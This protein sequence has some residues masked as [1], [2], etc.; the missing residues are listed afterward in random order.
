MTTNERLPQEII[1][2]N[3]NTEAFNPE[4]IESAIYRCLNEGCELDASTSGTIAHEVSTRVLNILRQC[5]HTPTVED[6]QNV[7]I[8]QLWASEYFDAATRYVIYREARRK[9]RENSQPVDPYIRE[10]VEQDNKYFPT[11]YQRYQFLSKYSRYRDELGRRE[12]W[13]EAIDRTMLFLKKAVEEQ[14]GYR[15][16]TEDYN[17]LRLSMLNMEAFPAMRVFQMAGPALERCH[18][19]AYNCSFRAVDSLRAFSEILYVLMQ[20]SGVGFSVE[21]EYTDKLPRIKKA[22]KDQTIHYFIVEDSTE[23]WCDALLFGLERWFAGEDVIFNYD[24]I[25]KQGARLKIKG[26]RASGPEPL[27]GLL[28]FTR[29]KIS[30][31]WESG[32]RLETIECHDIVCKL[33]EIVMVGGVRRAAEISLS[34]LDDLA[35]RSAKHGQ[36]WMAE[37]QRAMANNSSVYEEKPTAEEFLEEWLSLIKSRTGERGIWNRAGYNKVKP[38]RRK[39]AKWG[40]NPCGEIALRN[41]QFCNLSI[42]IARAWDTEETLIE[43]VRQ[44]TIFG[45]LQST[46]TRFNY[47]GEEW[48]RNCEEERL[49][50]VDITGQLD[51]PLLRPGAPGRKELLN[52]L[53]EVAGATNREWA[54]ILGIPASTAITCVKPSGNSSQLFNCS[55]GLHG[56]YAPYYKRRFRAGRFDPLTQMLID[57]GLNWYPEVGQTKE[58]CTVVVFEFPVASP[59]GAV[60][61]DDLDAEQQ[62]L[63]WLEWKKEYTEHNPSVTIYCKEDEWIKLGHL[64][65]ENWDWVGGLSFLPFDKHL[66]QLSPYEACSRDEYE[67]MVKDFPKIDW[68]RLVTYETEDHT[69]VKAELACVA[70]ACEL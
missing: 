4:K 52:K 66:Y 59:E 10:A 30:R 50:G 1:K 65:Y 63:N 24:S 15:L 6:V 70:G 20:G 55:S 13:E 11:E 60:L 46:L 14:T 64:V 49:L 26:G 67:T 44:A 40:V 48:K 2:R 9:E 41:C 23:G 45:T 57:V 18:V 32:G 21:T 5:S 37:P 29:T 58:N 35:M 69:D 36:F 16:K 51:C 17:L 27:K 43:K 3:G 39:A 56:R 62:F 42:C 34:D 38:K 33:G 68:S 22:K 8:Q 54:A 47:I 53:K 12:T 31:Y 19:G 7:V 61:R 25:R 28:D